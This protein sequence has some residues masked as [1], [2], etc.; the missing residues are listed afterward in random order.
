MPSYLGSTAPAKREERT[1]QAFPQCPR[2]RAGRTPSISVKFIIH[3][4]ELIIQKRSIKTRVRCGKKHQF[5]QT[6]VRSLLCLVH[7]LTHS[8]MLWRLHL[9]NSKLLPIL[10]LMLPTACQQFVES[11]MTD[12]WPFIS[13]GN[14]LETA[15]WQLK[16]KFCHAW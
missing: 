12:W 2:S 16:I 11:L 15:W 13:L 9:A 4:F 8:L 3:W 7:S 14:F 10:I 5:Y 6:F 1:Q